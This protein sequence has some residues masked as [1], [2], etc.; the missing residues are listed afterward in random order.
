[1]GEYVRKDAIYKQTP[2][3]TVVDEASSLRNQ[4]E[5]LGLLG[6]SPA[7]DK[8]FI[9]EGNEQ[10]HHVSGLRMLDPVY[11]NTNESQAEQLNKILP[12]GHNLLNMALMK[13][14]VHQGEK[15]AD[16]IH[17]WMRSQG[18]EV[19]GYLQ[20]GTFIAL[21]ESV[22]NAPFEQKVAVMKCYRDNILPVIKEKVNDLL[23]ESLNDKYDR[24]LSGIRN[25]D[26]IMSTI[27][28]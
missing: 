11:A 15:G 12:T 22:R 1:M 25:I 2:F 14:E 5:N 9:P 6:I 18:L 24:T 23:N 21:A 13:S 17:N 28:V 19:S 27:T 20:E 3:D 16:S 26:N 4:A 10:V 7:A 8:F